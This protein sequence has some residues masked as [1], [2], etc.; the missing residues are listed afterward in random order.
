[1][2]SQFNIQRKR[3]F[4][5]KQSSFIAQKL[6]L[7]SWKFTH[8]L[9]IAFTVKGAYAFE[10]KSDF[11]RQALRH[12]DQLTW[13]VKNSLPLRQEWENKLNQELIYL[14]PE[15]K[16]T[17]RKD[18]PYEKIQIALNLAREWGAKHK[19]K[20]IIVISLVGLTDSENKKPLNDDFF[21]P[22]AVLLFFRPK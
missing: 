13:E 6:L 21:V 18:D 12:K 7:Y 2:F 5:L 14:D 8:I 15:I 9:V 17:M 10:S 1:M 22:V 20:K 3:F 4:K 11:I 19:D 16:E